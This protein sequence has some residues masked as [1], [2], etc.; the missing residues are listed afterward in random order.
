MAG[1]STEEFEGY[2]T[3][4][5]MENYS[6]KFE[7]EVEIQNRKYEGTDHYILRAG[8]EVNI[9][10]HLGQGSVASRPGSSTK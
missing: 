3:F 5:S 8:S 9:R 6:D 10:I 2:V 4:V 1:D 7:I